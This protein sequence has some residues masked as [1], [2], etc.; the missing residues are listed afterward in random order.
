[1][2]TLASRLVLTHRKRVRA[3]FRPEGKRTA[4]LGR[5]ACAAYP[6]P[7][8]TPGAAKPEDCFPYDGHMPVN[9]RAETWRRGE[10]QETW[11]H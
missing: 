4:G 6:A 3:L 9:R 11:K 10:K 7:R 8:A 1:M 5:G 2:D